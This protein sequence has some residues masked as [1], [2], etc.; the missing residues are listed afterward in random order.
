MKAVDGNCLSGWNDEINI[1]EDPR[2]NPWSLLESGKRRGHRDKVDK[3]GA[4][5]TCELPSAKLRI[6]VFVSLRKQDGKNSTITR[7]LDLVLD[8]VSWQFLSFSK[9]CHAADKHLNSRT[10][11]GIA[12]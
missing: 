6:T 4:A 7:D 12:D 1:G 11:L 10:P 2:G 5:G 9:A 3:G 8:S